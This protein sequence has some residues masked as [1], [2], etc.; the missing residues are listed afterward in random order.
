MGEI[1]LLIF[2]REARSGGEGRRERQTELDFARSCSFEHVRR[3]R[4]GRNCILHCIICTKVSYLQENIE[5]KSISN[6]EKGYKI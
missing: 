5:L 1:C 3:V 4:T 6:R 2:D